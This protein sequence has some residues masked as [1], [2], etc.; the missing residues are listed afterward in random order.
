MVVAKKKEAG[1]QPTATRRVVKPV[2]SSLSPL[3]SP[4]CFLILNLRRRDA[5]VSVGGHS[6]LI[7][8]LAAVR[9]TP[10]LGRGRVMASRSVFVK[11]SEDL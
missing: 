8:S 9:A 11:I 3:V 2:P 5:C 1:G 4:D 6:A 10:G 7:P